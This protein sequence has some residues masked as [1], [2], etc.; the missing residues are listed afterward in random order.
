MENFTSEQLADAALEASVWGELADPDEDGRA[1]LLEYAQATNPNDAAADPL[2]MRAMVEGDVFQVVVRV[3]KDD[4]TLSVE[5]ESSS[6]LMGTAWVVGDFLEGA[7]R[8]GDAMNPGYEFIT[9]ESAL[10]EERG[11]ARLSVA[12]GEGE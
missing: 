8:V 7:A 12:I 3:R 10:G 4:P 2:A 5:V 9:Y 6:S 1:N 11:F